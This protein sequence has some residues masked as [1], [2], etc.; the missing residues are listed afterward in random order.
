MTLHRRFDVD[1]QES[2]RRF[3]QSFDSAPIGMA[4]VALDGRWLE[5][6]ESLCRI[7]GY[8]EAELLRTTFQA[9]THPDDLEADLAAASARKATPADACRSSP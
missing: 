2:E 4:L 6:N 1:P 8:T 5:V 3:R 9:I 7:V